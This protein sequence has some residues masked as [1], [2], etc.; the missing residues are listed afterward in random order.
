MFGQLS[1]RDFLKGSAALVAALSLASWFPT[2]RRVRAQSS[3]LPAA[4][5]FNPLPSSQLVTGQPIADIS[6]GWDGTLWAVDTLG[7]PHRYDPLQQSWQPFGKG[8]DAATMVGDDFYLFQGSEVAVYNAAQGLISQQPIAAQWP[9]LPPSFTSDLDGAFADGT[10]LY[11]CRSG[12]YVSADLSS[13]PLAFSQPTALNTWPGWPTNDPWAQGVVGKA[14]TWLYSPGAGAGLI[15]PTQTPP[16]QVLVVDQSATPLAMSELG[17][18][19]AGAGQFVVD[20]LT[21]G[22]FDAYIA[23]DES[24]SVPTVNWVFQGPVVWTVTSNQPAAA[25][26]APGSLPGR[27]PSATRRAGASATSGA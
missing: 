21:A 19:I 13:S 7:I 9:G 10:L 17:T 12:R 25:A 27:R 15:F 16:V 26:W 3:P 18:M 1:R 2:P 22:D 6:A 24:D 4:P 20:I 11:L 23:Q 5:S 8:V 14:G